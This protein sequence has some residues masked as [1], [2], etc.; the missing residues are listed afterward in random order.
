MIIHSMLCLTASK[1]VCYTLTVHVWSP[2]ITV[3][4]PLSGLAASSLVSVAA[5][6]SPGPFPTFRSSAAAWLPNGRLYQTA[7]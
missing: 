1:V 7:A 4:M 3:A 6:A 2:D 5:V